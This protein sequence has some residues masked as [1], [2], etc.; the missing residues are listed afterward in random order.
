MTD[1]SDADP[2]ARRRVGIIRRLGRLFTREAG[3]AEVVAD[4]IRERE[5]AGE[6]LAGAQRDMVMRAARFDQLN[7]LEVM[8]P[9]AD[10][11]A[12]EVTATLGEAA[13]AFSDS[14]HSRLPVYG[15]GLDDPQGFVHVRDVLAL[16]A[17][18]AEGESR[19]KFSDRL[20]S[21]IKRD[22]LFV[23]P[24]MTLATLFLKMQSSRIHLALVVDEYGG[25]DGLVS[26]EDLVEQ[27]VGSIEDE[28]DV[29][30]MLIQERAGG[31]LDADGRAPI[32]QLGFVTDNLAHAVQS[33][34]D[35]F[36]VGPWTI[37][38]NVVLEGEY[39][40]VRAKVEINVALG[41]RGA[42]QIELI[43]VAST[44]PSPYQD[45]Q[46]RSLAGLHHVAWIV[47][48]LDTEARALEADGLAPVFKAHNPAIRVIYFAD[49]TQPG[50]LF[51]LITGPGARQQHTDGV[52]LA[53][54]WDG[55]NP[56]TE[57]DLKSV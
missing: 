45:A 8:R 10:I 13:R 40:G 15:E 26:M 25:T 47:D 24:S 4:A 9:R 51:E 30:A 23:P 41:Y 5:D 39:L 42:E 34:T 56:I 31:A 17:P 48:D 22:I 53:R 33:W 46:G 14:Q 21:R 38:R 11:V 54:T 28:H 43:E 50:V 1:P 6:P 16:L 44:T 49:D 37:Y 3:S 2:S 36:G 52:A 55:T 27:I 57:I 29:E 20:I 32:D 7:V 19:A 18:D 35:R 12:I